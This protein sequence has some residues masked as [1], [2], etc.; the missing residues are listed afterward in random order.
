MRPYVILVIIGVL[1]AGLAAMIVRN[2]APPPAAEQQP[3]AVNTVKV[4][5]AQDTIAAGSFV[6][7]DSQ[8]AWGEWPAEQAKS[9]SYLLE[10][11]GV[12][13][14]SYNGAVAR[15][16]IFAGEPITQASLVKPGEGGFMSAVLTP[17]KRAVS[18]AVTA[19][20]GN[21][22]FIFPGDAVDMILTHTIQ[23][24]EASHF[25]SE[26]FVEDVRVLAV[27]QMLDNP[28]NKAILAKTVTLEVTPQQA[29]AITVAQEM[30]KISLSL[31][32]LATQPAEQAKNTE[33]SSEVTTVKRDVLYF[34]PDGEPKS[35]RAYTRDRDISKLMG[36]GNENGVRKVRVIRG[37]SSTDLE[38]PMETK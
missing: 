6:K 26:T 13:P 37:K 16:T 35:E 4:L 19:T 12:S 32:S 5:I 10:S 22:G 8:L 30:G 15:R 3:V 28:E 34:Y 9:L 7:A 24:A 2:A 1:I 21:A 20:T 33:D 36:T 25:A 11:V 23:Q 38:F 31:R 17:G 14:Q 29:E 27:D 18:I